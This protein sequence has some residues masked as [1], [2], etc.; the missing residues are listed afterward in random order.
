MPPYGGIVLHRIRKDIPEIHHT[1]FFDAVLQPR[2]RAIRDEG[3][4]KF[5]SC[6]TKRGENTRI[7]HPGE[8][9]DTERILSRG[10]TRHH[11]EIPRSEDGSGFVLIT[12]KFHGHLHATEDAIVVATLLSIVCGLGK[13]ET[14]RTAIACRTPPQSDTKFDAMTHI[15]ASHT[16]RILPMERSPNERRVFL[17]Q[18]VMVVP[19]DVSQEMRLDDL[20]GDET[21][22]NEAL[23]ANTRIH[24]VITIAKSDNSEIAR[25]FRHFEHFTC[26]HESRR[27]LTVGRHDVAEHVRIGN[28]R[29][30]DELSELFFRTI[31]RAFLDLIDREIPLRL[32]TR[33]QFLRTLGRFHFLEMLGA[34]AFECMHTQTLLVRLKMVRMV[35]TMHQIIR[36]EI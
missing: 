22:G 17:E 5:I 10:S 3:R 4:T 21:F 31:A 32:Q 9:M 1:F 20:G 28:E 30:V 11:T 33:T 36:D 34:Q 27:R 7:M 12:V 24:P 23:S 6:R 16:E 19:R 25:I 29:H 8:S 2:R 35:C 26:G 13:A 18:L 15:K 14:I